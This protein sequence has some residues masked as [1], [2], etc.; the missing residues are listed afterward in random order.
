MTCNWNFIFDI[1]PGCRMPLNS[2]MFKMISSYVFDSIITS[3]LKPID[4]S[5]YL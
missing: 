3:C 4:I 1:S 2:T 5:K